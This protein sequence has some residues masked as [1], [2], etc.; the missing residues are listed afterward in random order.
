MGGM[1]P[2]LNTARLQL[3]PATSSDAADCFRLDQDPDVMRHLGGVA[4]DD[5]LALARQR[6]ERAI[7]RHEGD[8][9]LGLGV[10]RL[11]SD[12]HFI[13]WFMLKP[14]HLEL[15]SELGGWLPQSDHVEV[16]YRL[17]RA[18]W[19]MGYATE[20]GRRLVEHGF[21]ELGL[22]EV[23]GVTH[24]ENHASR[25]VLSKLGL[26]PRGRALYRG[27]EVELHAA[28]QARG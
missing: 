8:V 11:K 27:E 3:R 18:D 19:G 2:I 17:A 13:G 12:Q 16:G 10:C 9:G 1:L 15:R 24:L 4:V 6:L 21:V 26:V 28:K 23:V 20:M 14:C 7:A 5:S 22:A 25:R